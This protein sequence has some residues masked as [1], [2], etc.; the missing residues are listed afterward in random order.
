MDSINSSGVN[1]L[2]VKLIWVSKSCLLLQY[3]FHE[4]TDETVRNATHNV[5][6]KSPDYKLEIQNTSST[7]IISLPVKSPPFCG[8]P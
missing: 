1:H 7:F 3:L 5:E 8:T 4:N 2:E 6:V